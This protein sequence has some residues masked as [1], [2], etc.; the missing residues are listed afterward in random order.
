M[1][2]LS[3]KPWMWVLRS[4]KFCLPQSRKRLYIIM[5]R[6]DVCDEKTVQNLGEIVQKVL[7]QAMQA[8][9]LRSTL[10]QVMN[11]N[12]TWLGALGKHRTLP[13]PSKD[14]GGGGLGVW[15]RFR[16][17]TGLWVQPAQVGFPP[18]VAG[19]SS[20]TSQ[21]L[22]FVSSGRFVFSGNGV[23]LKG[24]LRKQLFINF[25]E[26]NFNICRKCPRTGPVR[27]K[28]RNW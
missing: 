22:G 20:H 1:W 7:P 18:R 10:G 13:L 8:A 4:S 17:G 25:Q 21:R 15:F 5:V 12:K 24:Q 19:F 9:G 23:T 6:D 3:T 28:R 27:P 26:T 16:C 11:L 14:L 2:L